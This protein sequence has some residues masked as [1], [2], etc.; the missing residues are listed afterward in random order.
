MFV[1][2][3]GFGG[4]AMLST[5]DFVNT[6]DAPNTEQAGLPSGAGT[7]GT[8]IMLPTVTV[9]AAP[10]WL[11]PVLVVGALLLLTS[12]KHGA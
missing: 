8:P 11:L 9:H 3:Q 4:I 6:D 7:V 2:P 12:G 10:P 1:P 5:G